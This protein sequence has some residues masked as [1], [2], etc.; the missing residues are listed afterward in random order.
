M[1]EITEEQIAKEELVDQTIPRWSKYR[2]EMLQSFPSP[3]KGEKD[4]LADEITK[5]IRTLDQ[6]KP[7][8][9]GGAAFLGT[10]P[11]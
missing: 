9:K 8:K 11:N 1:S 5:A 3:Y 2:S 6:L 10:D 7:E 4:S